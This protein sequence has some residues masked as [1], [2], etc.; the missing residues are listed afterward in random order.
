MY[1]TSHKYN[2]QQISS[3]SA[4]FQLKD[5]SSPYDLY[6]YIILYNIIIWKSSGN[7]AIF[8]AGTVEH[9]YTHMVRG[10]LIAI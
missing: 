9:T 8:T 1:C 2:L 5:T 4:T 3:Y 6:K 7:V 10:F